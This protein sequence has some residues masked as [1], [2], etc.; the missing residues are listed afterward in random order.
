MQQ[1]GTETKDSGI[2][3]PV[4][5]GSVLCGLWVLVVVNFGELCVYRPRCHS[6]LACHD[7][8]PR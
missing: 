8:V 6:A 2:P 4:Y 3:S 5:T 1:D 7:V